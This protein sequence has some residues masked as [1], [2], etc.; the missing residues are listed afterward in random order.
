MLLILSCLMIIC[1]VGAAGA[2]ASSITFYGIWNEADAENAFRKRISA[3]ERRD[4]KSRRGSQREAV[5]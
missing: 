2:V 1:E 5:D 4:A 3:R